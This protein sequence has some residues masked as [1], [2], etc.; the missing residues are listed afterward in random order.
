MRNAVWTNAGA[1]NKGGSKI[2][3]KQVEDWSVTQQH[4]ESNNTVLR[5]L[6]ILTSSEKPSRHISRNEVP[7]YR[8]PLHII[9]P[10]VIFQTTSNFEAQTSRPP[11]HGKDFR[12]LI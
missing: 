7:C 1:G 11:Q 3:G 6:S 4:S 8:A 10:K 5:R 2:G 9:P 12:K